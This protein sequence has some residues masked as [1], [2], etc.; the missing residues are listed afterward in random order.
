VMEC[1]GW[2]GVAQAV[3]LWARPTQHRGCSS[4]APVG[5]GKSPLKRCC[6]QWPW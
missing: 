5:S 4:R 3:E 1:W 6:P 2:V